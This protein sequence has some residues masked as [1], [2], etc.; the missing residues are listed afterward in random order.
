MGR[1]VYVVARDHPELYAYLCEN[2]F[3]KAIATFNREL[4]PIRSR[5][6]LERIQS[7][8]PSWENFVPP[9]IVEIIKREHLFGY[10][11]S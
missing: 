3:I 5:V 7:G 6:V 11:K 4:L 2:G 8:D 9:Q 10:A 1:T